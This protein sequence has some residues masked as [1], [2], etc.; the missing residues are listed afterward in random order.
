MKINVWNIYILIIH[1]ILIFYFV[2][3]FIR[4]VGLN[5]FINLV[6]YCIIFF[7]NLIMVFFFPTSTRGLGY[8]AY[9]TLSCKL[10]N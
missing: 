3:G 10:T 5:T 4:V 7:V 9:L 1:C 6:N 8:P 2:G